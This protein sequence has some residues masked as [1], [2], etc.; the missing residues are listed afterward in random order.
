MT[1]CQKLVTVCPLYISISGGYNIICMCDNCV[2]I[3]K[4][5]VT[6]QC[7]VLSLTFRLSE[8]THTTSTQ[9]NEHTVTPAIREF[10]YIFGKA[11]SS[12]K[13]VAM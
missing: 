9:P 10:R 11:P 2:V 5:E 1:P 6:L 3:V 4:H 8:G 12:H 7:T 13:S